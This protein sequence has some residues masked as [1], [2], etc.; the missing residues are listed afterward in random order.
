MLQHTQTRQRAGLASLAEVEEARRSALAAQTSL[1]T[2]ALERQLAW[3]NLYRAAGGGWDGNT[4]APEAT[5]NVTSK[6]TTATTPDA[7]TDITQE[8]AAPAGTARPG[9]A[10]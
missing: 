2:L 5:S 10:L 7:T 4:A 3:I 9:P 1:S 8:A 6:A